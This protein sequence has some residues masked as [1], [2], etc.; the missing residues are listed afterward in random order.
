MNNF[1]YYLCEEKKD[2]KQAERLSAKTVEK[3]PNNSTF[4]DTYAWILF[5]QAN[6]SLAKY[7]IERAI[8]NI[9]DEIDGVIFEH[10]GDILWIMKIDDE[11][12]L[13][14][15]Q[16]AYNAGI[17]SDILKQKID[18]KGWKRD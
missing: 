16:K 7:Y 4:L 15:W 10:Y 9:K 2:L 18:N 14:M 6:Y 11:K 1:A 13:S 3:F 5:Q 12:A 8:E 17:K